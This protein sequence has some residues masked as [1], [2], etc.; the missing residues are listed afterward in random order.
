MA[1]QE[2]R[3][4]LAQQVDNY[5]NVNMEEDQDMCMNTGIHFTTSTC[6]HGMQ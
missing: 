4:Y 3:N 1:Q 2:D 6:Q 5:D